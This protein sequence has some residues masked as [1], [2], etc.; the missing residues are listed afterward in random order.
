MTT[1]TLDDLNRLYKQPHPLVVAKT[2]D[3]IEQSQRLIRNN[4]LIRS[5]PNEASPNGADRIVSHRW[6]VRCPRETCW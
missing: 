6:L 4:Y 5:R 2:L 1:L 3:H